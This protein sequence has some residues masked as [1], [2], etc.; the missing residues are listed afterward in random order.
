MYVCINIKLSINGKYL[1]L[2]YIL[3]IFRNILIDNA[4]L[5]SYVHIF[6]SIYYK[7]IAL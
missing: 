4:I 1:Q 2:N 6:D 3:Y 5:M 7:C